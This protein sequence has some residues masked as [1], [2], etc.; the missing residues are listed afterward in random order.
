[1]ARMGLLGEVEADDRGDVRIERIV[2]GEA[3][4]DRVGYR[5]VTGAV[6]VQETRNAQVGIG[7]EC[8]RIQEVVV[9]AAV[10]DVH[11]AQAGGRP[12]VHDVVVDEQIPA[13]DQC[14]AHF[15]REK[16]MFEIGGVAD[17]GREHHKGGIGDVGSERAKRGEQRLA[18]MRNRPH[19][20]PVEKRRQD[21]LGDLAVGEHIG[22]AAWNPE[23]VFEHDEGAVGRPDQ[24]GSRNRDV[25]VAVD[26]DAAHL[27]PVMP[28]AQ[29]QFARD[30][31]L[32]EYSRVV[33]DVLEEQVDGGEPLR[34][35]ALEGTPFSRG[36]DPRQEVEGK[37]SLRA[38]R[39]AVDG[40]GNALR[41]ERPIGLHLTLSQI[42][43]RRGLQFSKERLAMRMGPAR[44]LEHLVERPAELVPGKQGAKGRG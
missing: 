5:D 22:D 33:V 19:L 27:A 7:S 15:A 38:L 44:R 11:T 21:A 6:R 16:G 39:V 30:N 18:V 25:D 34:E 23:V 8:Q 35:A 24:I 31:P 4:A 32:G 10:D 28:A 20:I 2:V 37:D 13:F 42:H 43:G 40:E 41:Q 12:H 17:A 9:H 14:D 1:M 36:D 3:R 29:H 26:A